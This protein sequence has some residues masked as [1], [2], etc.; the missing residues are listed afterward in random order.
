M[1]DVCLTSPV[2]Y[3]TLSLG[4][5]QSQ[6]YSLLHAEPDS[7]K[8]PFI[9]KSRTTQHQHRTY[10]RSNVHRGQA[11]Q[12]GIRSPVRRSFRGFP[13]AKMRR[14]QAARDSRNSRWV[15]RCKPV[16]G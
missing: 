5:A 12:S 15:A 13:E 2:L 8:H 3:I 14:W 16:R 6:P 4:E 7:A 1:P 11:S 9:R 10:P